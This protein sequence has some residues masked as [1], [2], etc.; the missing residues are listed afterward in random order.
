MTSPLILNREELV[1]LVVKDA[2]MRHFI[3]SLDKGQIH[4][5]GYLFKQGLLYKENPLMLPK[6]A[7][8]I[9]KILE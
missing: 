7:H 8:V 9:P 4:G 5:L 1:D 2:E 3:E 6:E